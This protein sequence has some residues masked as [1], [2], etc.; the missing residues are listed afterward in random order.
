M[1]AAWEPKRLATGLTA[2]RESDSEGRGG[3]QRIESAWQA[4]C[5]KGK[6][7]GYGESSPSLFEEA[8]QQ[9]SID[10]LRGNPMQMDVSE[11]KVCFYTSSTQ[12]FSTLVMQYPL[13]LVIFLCFSNS[14]GWINTTSSCKHKLHKRCVRVAILIS[15]VNCF[16]CHHTFFP[17]KILTLMRGGKWR[18][19]I[20]LIDHYY[21]PFLPTN[22]YLPTLDF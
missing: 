9:P 18:G 6:G 11:E 21:R 15:K 4:H 1:T 16:N 13:S 20:P 7:E 22:I 17:P 8:D 14:S 3:P 10:A 5:S 2:D 12:F 19:K